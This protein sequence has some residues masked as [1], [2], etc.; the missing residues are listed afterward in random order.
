MTEAILPKRDINVAGDS[1]ARR[2][3]VEEMCGEEAGG[4]PRI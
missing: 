4:Q 1:V 3:T 2:E